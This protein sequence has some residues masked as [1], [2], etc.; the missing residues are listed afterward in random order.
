VVKA[1]N[2][3]LK[4]AGTGKIKIKGSA[5]KATMKEPALT[6][7]ID[8]TIRLILDSNIDGI[9]SLYNRAV[10]D[11]FN[12]N[13]DTISQWSS[14]KTVTKSVLFPT[15]TNEQRIKD[16]IERAGKSVQEGDKI[17]VYFKDDTTLSIC[18]AFDGIYSTKKLLGKLYNTI[19]IFETVLNLDVFPNY[20]LKKNQ[21]RLEELLNERA[22]PQT[23]GD[24]EERGTQ[25]NLNLD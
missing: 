5:L 23:L 13:K 15:R 19:G 10:V 7:F 6:K 24:K 22:T 21:K 16:S 11:I 2:Y 14:K 20:T 25:L 1:K 4:E 17:Y 3:V 18:E 12:V 9:E 8:D